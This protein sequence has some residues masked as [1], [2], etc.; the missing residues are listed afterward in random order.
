MN[1][2]V[3]ILAGGLATRLRPLTENLPKSMIEIHGKPFF[4]YQLTLLKK[5]G[6]TNIVACVGYQGKQI[7]KYFGD[8]SRFGVDLKYSYDGETLLGTGGSLRQALPLLSDTFLVIYGD[9]YLDIPYLPVIQHFLE[10]YE[11]SPDHPLALM[12]VYEDD[13]QREQSNV[14]F[15]AG[16]IIKYDK[17]AYDAKM[18]HIDWGLSIFS[19]QAFTASSFPPRFDLTDVYQQLIPLNQLIGYEVFERYYEIGSHRGLQEFKELMQN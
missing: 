18:K 11:R 7:E 10:Q 4:E 9:S 13:S 17:Q 3:A 1:T 14:F 5:Q 16:K 15:D 2:S 19:K 12:T 6:L 8:G